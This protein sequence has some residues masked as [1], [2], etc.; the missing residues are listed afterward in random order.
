MIN[1]VACVCSDPWNLPFNVLLFTFMFFSFA[2]FV[3]TLI[4]GRAIMFLNPVVFILFL[5]DQVKLI[6]FA[7]ILMEGST[8]PFALFSNY[9]FLFQWNVPLE[10]IPKMA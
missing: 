3:V 10:H 4:G 6:K 2:H 9:Q 5:R 7:L 8:W 1:A